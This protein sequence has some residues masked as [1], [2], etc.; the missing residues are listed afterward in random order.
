MSA[1]S[2]Q[3]STQST[4]KSAPDISRALIANGGPAASLLNTWN[5]VR[6]TCLF[7]KPLHSWRHASIGNND[8]LVS[9]EWEQPMALQAA[10]CRIGIF[11][12]LT[13]CSYHDPTRRPVRAIMCPL[14]VLHCQFCKAPRIVQPSSVRTSGTLPSLHMSLMSCTRCPC[15]T[16]RLFCTIR[17][18]TQRVTSALFSNESIFGHMSA[19]SSM[20]HASLPA[21][22]V[23]HF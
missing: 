11:V 15:C 17:I 10:C 4:T 13:T 21:K 9:Q 1:H 7:L 19:V 23:L 22:G 20:R 2:H 8:G 16:L 5:R 3:E 12:H 6:V 18:G 14:G